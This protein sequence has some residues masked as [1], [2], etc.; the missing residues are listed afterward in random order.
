MNASIKQSLKKIGLYHPLQS[1]F[2]DTIS[3]LQ[4]LRYKTSYR[5]YKGGGF[6][7]NFCGASYRRFVP[8][9]PTADIEQAI[10]SNKVIAG[11][12]ENV[13]CPNC[14]SKNRERLIKDVLD[15]YIDFAGKSILHFSP[16]KKLYQYIQ[17]KA[18]VTTIDLEPGFYKTIDPTIAQGDAT[19]LHFP[20]EQFDIIIANHILEHI[21]DDEKAMK[22]IFRVLKR[23]GVAILQ[24]PWSTNLPT[25]IEDR[26]IADPLQQAILFG[27]KD[28]VRIYTLPDYTSRLRRAGFTV[29]C[30]APTELAQFQQHAIQE[31]EPV[32]LGY[33]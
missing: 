33:K 19:Q 26:S 8:K 4:R 10:N 7:C 16:E 3:F 1:A 18:R 13:F 30:I 29:T 12:G 25:T 21:P 11:F 23:N 5:K 31:G 22:E 27:Q 6:E 2:R 28:H 15:H 17:S 24:A 9:Y 14:L 20:D 32:V